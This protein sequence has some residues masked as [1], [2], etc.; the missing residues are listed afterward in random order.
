MAM[1]CCVKG[2]HNI[3][4]IKKQRTGLALFFDPKCD[5]QQRKG[6]GRVDILQGD[7]E[8]GWLS[9]N[10]RAS[11]SCMERRGECMRGE[12]KASRT[13]C[14]DHFADG[15]LVYGA[16]NKV[17]QATALRCKLGES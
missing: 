8:N 17:N 14:S 15:M 3:K 6:T 2:C 7:E 9:R 16:L 12:S 4:K 13:V 5:D 11:F 1:R 10:P